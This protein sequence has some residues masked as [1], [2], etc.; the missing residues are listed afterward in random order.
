MNRARILANLGR[1]HTAHDVYD[2]WVELRGECILVGWDGSDGGHHTFCILSDGGVQP[3]GR[4]W[5]P[6][7]RDEAYACAESA[8]GRLRVR[9]EWT[10]RDGGG[11]GIVCT[12][13]NG[14]EHVFSESG[15]SLVNPATCFA[16]DGTPWVAWIRCTDVENPDGV[17]DQIN[18]IECA[19]FRNGTWMRE[20]VAD[21]RSGLLPKTN[22]WG[23]PGRR[24][25][26]F[27]APDDRGG[28]WLFWERKEPHNGPTTQAVGALCGRRWA[29]GTWQAPVRVIEDGFF[30]YVPALRGVENGALTVAAQ[31][32]NGEDRGGV[33]VLTVSV[34]GASTLGSDRGFPP[35]RCVNL[36]ERKWFEPADRD[37]AHNGKEYRLLFGDPHTH[38]AFSEDAE[39]EFAELLA[40]ARDKAKIDFV[41]FTDND[42][43]YGGRLSDRDW[44]RTMAIEQ[45]WSEDGRFIAVPAYEWT[46]ARWGPIQPQH[47]SIL[48]TSYDQ[49]ILRWSDVEGDPI[50]AL[51][52]WIQTTDGI[53]NTQH[54]QFLLTQSDREANM[55]VC[56]GWGDYI[57]RSACFHEHLDRGFRVGFVG[58]SDGHRRTPG[59]GGGLTGLWVRDFTLAG[60]IDAFRQRRCYATAG[61]RIGLKFWVND[62]FMGETLK[63]DAPPAARVVVE[64]PREIEK[65]ELFGDGRILA[66][67]ETL[68]AVCDVRFPN[69]PRCSWYYAKVT[70]PDGFPEYP[71]NIAPAEGPWAWSSPVFME[72]I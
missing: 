13:P 39:G 38:T 65:I 66:M 11:P 14:M 1:R 3:V 23:Y 30:G 45:D 17:I 53:M 22:V 6:V 9:T 51:V 55:E 58:T 48:F 46:Q 34:D 59:L 29:D 44:R 70:L 4:P 50:E 64:A 72:K 31:N 56:C 63:A 18:E 27:L 12:F 47:R 62:A 52:A 32:A 37:L 60:I 16:S 5:A 42:Y 10:A 67:R 21:L 24:R 20:T 15:V 26:P 49:P 43:I 57:N 7:P 54:S 35:W 33:V 68:P 36:L 69:L 28:V 40:Y 8:H 61:T 25:R 71:G 19:C 2:L 41:A